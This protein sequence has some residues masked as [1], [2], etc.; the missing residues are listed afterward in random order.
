MPGVRR[1]DGGVFVY[2]CSFSVSRERVMKFPT[3]LP[4]PQPAP[5]RPGSSGISAAGRGR[6]EHQSR[7]GGGTDPSRPIAF[8][9]ELDLSELDERGRPGGTWTG[10]AQDLSRST[11][12]FRSRRLCY[13]G[14]E[15]LVA[16]HLVDDRPVI[17]FG[18]VSRSDYDGDGLYKTSIAL[19][20]L[21][22]S[23]AVQRWMNAL[24]NRNA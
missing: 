12:T 10:R 23:E 8:R 4:Q 19:A 3:N 1:T 15:L 17:L 18:R 20:E 2:P 16:I 7:A 21:P 6:D 9:A 24:A 13:E 22:D 14:R 11:L 5:K